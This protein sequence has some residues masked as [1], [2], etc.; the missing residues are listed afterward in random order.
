MCKHPKQRAVSTFFIYNIALLCT[1]LCVLFCS[2]A[3]ASPTK[4]RSTA[5]TKPEVLPPVLQVAKQRLT[6]MLTLFQANRYDQALKLMSPTIRSSLT[7]AQLRKQMTLTLSVTGPFVKGSLSLLRH[8]MRQGYHRLM[9]RARFQKETGTIWMI[10]DPK[11]YIGGLII[12]SPKLLQRLRQEE[13][14]KA[15]SK[16]EQRSLR[17]LLDQLFQGYNQRKWAMFCGHCS[18]IMKGLL[19]PPRFQQ[20]LKQLHQRYGRYQRRRFV[21]FSKMKLSGM[22]IA[23]YNGD[24]SKHK[25]LRIRLTLQSAPKQQWILVA[26]QLLP[27]TP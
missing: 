17:S 26:W 16:A 12:R 15:L 13:K 2:T 5:R 10:F 19:Q 11:S 14:M 9:W 3:L 7:A 23:R 4:R 21:S 6:Q 8:E 1:S 24:F 18:P 27:Q 25:N 22:L 20:V